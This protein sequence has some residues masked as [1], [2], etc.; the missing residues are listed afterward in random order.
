MAKMYDYRTI[1]VGTDGSPLAVP[2]VARAA[3][4]AAHDDADLVI[5]CA[6]SELSRRDEARNVA[7][8]GGDARI[9]Q[10]ISRADATTAIAAAVSVAKEQSAT[11]SAALLVD[12]EPASALLATAAER[13]ADLIVVGALRDTSIAGRL[14]G[15][16]A[17]EVVRRAPCDV[18]IVRPRPDAA[19]QPA[20]EEPATG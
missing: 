18:L 17:T 9:G 16:V 15:T 6:Y 5:A 7:T 3:W 10:V 2:T 8:L 20:A 14:L 1:V 12:G 13:A 4:L 19:Q 11:I